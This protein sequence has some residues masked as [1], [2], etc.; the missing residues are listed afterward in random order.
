MGPS[1]NLHLAVR[2]G[3][4][5]TGV[6]KCQPVSAFCGDPSRSLNA[7]RALSVDPIPSLLLPTLAFRT[8]CANLIALVGFQRP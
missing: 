3:A 8:V 4:P 1:Q 5:A 6:F 2:F 7:H